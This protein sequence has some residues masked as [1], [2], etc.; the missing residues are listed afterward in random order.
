MVVVVAAGALV[1]PHKRWMSVWYLYITI[2]DDE[3]VELK[4]IF[5]RVSIPLVAVVSV[6]C[7]SGSRFSD[8]LGSHS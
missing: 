7:V 2:S 1:V 3:H 5:F 8:A 4:D 6:L